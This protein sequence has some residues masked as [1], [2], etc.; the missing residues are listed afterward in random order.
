M[1]MDKTSQREAFEQE[2]TKQL[3]PHGNTQPNHDAHQH[4]ETTETLNHADQPE[5]ETN[6][7]VKQDLQHTLILKPTPFPSNILSQEEMD[8]LERTN[9][10]AYMKMVLSSKGISIGR[11]SSS[12]IVSG[13]N[14]IPETVDKVLRQ[15]KVHLEGNNIFKALEKDF[16][17][18]YD[19]KTLLKK[20]DV[21]NAPSEVFDFMVTFGPFFIHIITDF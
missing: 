19:I 11:G 1:V 2:E 10:R 15:L 9:P 17:Y 4:K 5:V 14:N 20:L 12:S 21:R 6:P 13:G 3:T 7:I 8:V 18:D 16:I